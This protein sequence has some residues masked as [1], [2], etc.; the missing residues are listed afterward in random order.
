M[1]RGIVN[2]AKSKLSTTKRPEQEP[3]YQQNAAAA[4]DDEDDD[5]DMF[6]F[7]DGNRDSAASSSRGTFQK[8]GV[9]L[10]K[11]TGQ[12]V[13]VEQFYDMVEKSGSQVNRGQAQAAAADLVQSRERT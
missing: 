11:Q 1:F 3:D 7:N 6:A 13:G 12:F 2:K 9:T 8:V 5:D 10:D 4:V